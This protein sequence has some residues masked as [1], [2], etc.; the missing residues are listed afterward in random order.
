M[1]WRQLTTEKIVFLVRD[2]R[3][4]CISGAYH[5]RQ[6]PA[7]FLDR[8]I[9]GDVARCGRW[10][11]YYNYAE[12]KFNWGNG[13]DFAKYENL[14]SSPRL[15]LH[16]MLDAL[17]IYPIDLDRIDEAIK[18]QSFATRKAQIGNDEKE[19]RRNNMRKGIAGDWRNH[20]TTE[21]NDKI[22]NE[23]GWIMEKLGYDK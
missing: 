16:T 12:G 8:M 10:D 13:A 1:A 5:W 2:P 11:T 3:D 18:R 14:L 7:D 22:W 9:Q 23:L 4:I 15:E 17:D 21:M 6:S 20:F 19:L